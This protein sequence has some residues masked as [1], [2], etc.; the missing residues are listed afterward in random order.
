M[1][2]VEALHFVLIEADKLFS[3][4][5]LWSPPGTGKITLAQ[6][7]AN[8]HLTFHDTSRCQLAL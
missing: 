5:I 3:S 2:R 6:V 1:S 4:I 7:I 8:H